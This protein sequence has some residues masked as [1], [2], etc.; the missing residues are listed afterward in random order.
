MKTL[1]NFPYEHVL[2]LGL[3][4]SGTAAARVL[5]NSGINVIVNDHHAK[6]D[7]EIVKELHAKGANV[8]VG[9]HPIS[10]LDE[11]ELIVKNPGIP[12]SNPILIEAENRNIPIITEIEL[13][14]NLATES[15]IIGIT[16]SNGKTTTTTLV[17]E[18]LNKSNQPVK[19]A[20]NIG[21]VA[22]EVAESLE[23]NDTLLLEL[24]S[25]QLMGVHS[26]RPHIAVLLNLFE[27]HIDYH[28]TVQNYEQAKMNIFRNQAASDYLIFNLDDEKVTRAVKQAKAKLIPFSVR[29]K[30]IKGA[31]VNN[32]YI[33]FHE[34]PIIAQ[35]DIV[36]VGEHNLQNILAAISVAILSGATIAGIKKVLTEFI[37]VKHRLQYVATIHGRLFYND[38]KATNMLATEKALQAFQRPT[39]LL[40]GGLDRGDTYEDLIPSLKHVKAMVLFGE[41]KEKLKRTA[42][43][44]NIKHIEVVENVGEATEVA[45]KLSDEGDVILLSPACASWDQY[46]TFEERGDMFIHA[47]HILA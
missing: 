13:A 47:V 21:I 16:G 45:Y 30:H 2:V 32:G 22:T 39:I 9:S 34:E 1:E 18:M 33:Y 6:E 31:W 17:A 25:F 8:I 20:G 41:T 19:L 5:L 38:S 3:A 14:A 36:L 40:A 43:Q 28:G 26:F 35:E 37:G 11:V 7:A 42:E 10:I 27:A 12:Y 24:S 15:E 4:K 46:K 23:T 44:A 29:Q